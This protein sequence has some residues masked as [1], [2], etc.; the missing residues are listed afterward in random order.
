M[1]VD[2]NQEFYLHIPAH[3]IQDARLKASDKLVWAYLRFRQGENS[4]CWPSLQRMADDLHLAKST[5]GRAARHLEKLGL[6]KC[7]H[8]HGGNK[9]ANTYRL[10]TQNAPPVGTQNAPREVILGTQNAPIKY[11]VI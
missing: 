2:S 1:M 11:T 4:G 3:I 5:T 6:I 9:Q 7:S 10:G 8:V